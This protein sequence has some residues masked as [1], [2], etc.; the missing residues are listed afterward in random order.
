MDVQPQLKPHARPEIQTL[1]QFLVAISRSLSSGLA[2]A[3]ETAKHH[4]SFLRA[5][6]LLLAR[7]V[8][9]PIGQISISVLLRIDSRRL[10]RCL[11]P[12]VNLQT[13]ARFSQ[14]VELLQS[15][16]RAF[17]RRESFV[18]VATRYHFSKCPRQ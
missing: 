2:E 10:A 16:V 9:R 12:S 11:G 8:R 13:A 18:P 4:L 17:Q 14:G 6:A 1:A 7:L 3:P 15:H 5:C